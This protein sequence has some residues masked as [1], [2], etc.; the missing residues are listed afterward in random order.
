MSTLLFES[1]SQRFTRCYEHAGGYHHRAKLLLN[2]TRS[3]SLVFNVA[4]IAV[5]CYLIAL[6]ALFG[7]MP[8]NHNY[9]SLVRSIEEHLQLEDA[10]RE[11]ILSLDAVFGIC[12]I[13]DYHHGVP[14]EQD[15]VRIL[16]LCN[17]LDALIRSE[18]A[19]LAEKTR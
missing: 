6:C 4:A 11:S 2:Q 14:D 8:M 9:R 13:D 7:D 1:D 3:P 10:L 12:S 16:E 19:A 5:E 18:Q 17:S 15:K